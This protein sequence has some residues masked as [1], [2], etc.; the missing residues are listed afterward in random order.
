M[1]RPRRE[2]IVVDPQ[3][4]GL[5]D[6]IRGRLPYVKTHDE[7]IVLVQLSG[8]SYKDFGEAFEDLVS[9]LPNLE[10]TGRTRYNWDDAKI[11][12]LLNQ[13]ESV[14]NIA[15]ILNVPRTALFS[16]INNKKFV[17]A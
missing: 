17:R 7:Y 14:T 8:L 10:K 12:E 11:N 6:L 15:K 9:Q 2:R 16:H 1:S 3:Y 13:N 4:A 5:I